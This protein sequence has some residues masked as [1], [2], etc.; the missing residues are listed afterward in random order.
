[1]EQPDLY[2]VLLV[3][4]DA[5]QDVIRAA[6]RALAAKHHPDVGGTAEQ[7]AALN[8]AYAV[9]S[10]PVV[11][12]T[13]DRRRRAILANEQ[14]RASGPDDGTA[15]AASTSAGVAAAGG[16]GSV[17]DYG[18]YSGWTIEQVARHDP[19]FLEWFVRTPGGRPYHAEIARE[20][21][22]VQAVTA[23]APDPGN[24]GRSRR[25]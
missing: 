9:L 22:Q 20:L 13:Y 1:M 19:D 12:A 16:R 23:A 17:L 25:W 14:A 3:D 21:R 11:R 8:R 4:P 10:D 24:R 6:Y 7:M 5:D 15:S 18:R 2:H